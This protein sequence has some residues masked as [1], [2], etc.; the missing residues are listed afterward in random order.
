M[1]DYWTAEGIYGTDGYHNLRYNETDQRLQ[2]QKWCEIPVETDVTD[3][4]KEFLLTHDE[5]Y[6]A[7]EV[8]YREDED[9]HT[10]TIHLTGFGD[11][12]WEKLAEMRE[13]AE[14]KKRQAAELQRLRD[15]Q[16]ELKRQQAHE[17]NL[18][19]ARK[20]LRAAGELPPLEGEEAEAVPENPASESTLTTEGYTVQWNPGTVAS[21]GRIVY[22]TGFS[23][24]NPADS[25]AAAARRPPRVVRPGRRRPFPRQL[26]EPD[27]D[28]DEEDTAT[29]F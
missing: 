1:A 4:V 28:S 18:E 9:V 8:E 27:V 10:G 25:V 23:A 22:N 20:I 14:E 2:E 13:D 7:C 15:A 3:L 5:C 19:A 24:N 6:F 12:P 17:A 11:L 16:R 21:S 29:E 26:A